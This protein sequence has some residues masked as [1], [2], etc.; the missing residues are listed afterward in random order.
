MQQKSP[1]KMP[2]N[3]LT[4]FPLSFCPHTFSYE[5]AFSE[6]VKWQKFSE[7]QYDSWSM[8][9]K[10]SEMYMRFFC[11]MRWNIIWSAW[12]LAKFS[13]GKTLLVLID[14]LKWDFMGK[15]FYCVKML[16]VTQKIHR[17]QRAIGHWL[18]RQRNIFCALENNT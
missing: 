7:Y 9:G 11:R 13:Q 10:Q 5:P 3:H 14:L 8:K 16:A 15:C 1:D 17:D 6:S 12:C 2:T 4:F 18:A